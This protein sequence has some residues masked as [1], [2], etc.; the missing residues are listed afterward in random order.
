V[1]QFE[2]G[3]DFLGNLDPEKVPVHVLGGIRFR[4]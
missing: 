2:H 4:S 3:Q 1:A